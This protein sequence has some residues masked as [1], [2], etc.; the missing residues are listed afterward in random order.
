MVVWGPDFAGRSLDEIIT[1]ESAAADESEASAS[2]PSSIS[3]ASIEALALWVRAGEALPEEGRPPLWPGAAFIDEGAKAVLFLPETTARRMFDAAGGAAWIEGAERWTH[4]DYS[5]EEA[6]VFTTAAVLYF[7]LSGAFP[8]PCRDRDTLREDIREGVFIPP[9]MAA[10]GLSGEAAALITAAL[11][12]RAK[13]GDRQ[14][15]FADIAQLVETAVKP[16]GRR[17][18]FRA[19][20]PAEKAALEAERERFLRKRGK[21][22]K[23]G[24]FVRRNRAA[25][26]GVAV[27]V[28]IA[29]LVTGSLIRARLNRPGTRGMEG[30]EVVEWYYNAFSALDHE[31]LEACV[32]GNAGKD[33]ITLVTNFFILGRVRQAYEAQVAFISPQLWRESGGVSGDKAV[34]GIDGLS[35]EGIDTDD[36]DGR[37]VYRAEYLFFSPVPVDPDA[38]SEEPLP[39]IVIPRR[40]E[41]VL[42]KDRK[43]LWHISEIR[44]T[45]SSPQAID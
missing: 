24:R 17:G 41:L 34:F 9:H 10:P 23:T 32:T 45:T 4:P 14:P 26:T 3:P 13:T 21:A 11:S 8:Y 29:A 40:D 22:V 36:A 25:I 39:F 2:S 1:R 35:L 15:A 28:V 30:V 6:A 33:D 7:A 31:A 19:L 16:D 37:L 18:L 27:A 43:G 5:G 38:E 44:R 12:P 20:T 42:E